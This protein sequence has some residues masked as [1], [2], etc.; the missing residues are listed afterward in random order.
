MIPRR[1]HD[2][3]A[4]AVEVFALDE[5]LLFLQRLPPGLELTREGELTRMDRVGRIN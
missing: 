5:R 1:E 2:E 4:L 3:R